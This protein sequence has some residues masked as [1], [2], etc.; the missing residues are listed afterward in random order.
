MQRAELAMIDDRL[1]QLR[2]RDVADE[3]LQPS[4]MIVGALGARPEDP[5]KAVLWNE[6]VD[7]IFGYRQR[8]AVSEDDDNPL[9][10]R[11]GEAARRRERREVEVRL[12]RIQR[13]LGR[14][15]VRTMER[16]AEI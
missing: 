4:E 8:Y 6:G 15:Q 1:I 12:K 16:G 13:E 11:P 3:R 2:R 5:A 7:L 14:E 9:G 10:P